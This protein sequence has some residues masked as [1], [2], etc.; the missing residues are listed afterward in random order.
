MTADELKALENA[1][2]QEKEAMENITSINLTLTQSLTKVQETILVISKQLKALQ[3]QKN[4]KKP[5]T[6]KPE[7]DNNQYLNKSKRYWWTHG[8]THSL[9]HTSAACR[10]LNK[11]HQIG[12]TLDSRMGGSDR[13]CKEYQTHE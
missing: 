6:E 4:T 9:N 5:A 1:T 7:T 12:A 10:Y 11:G 2:T 8:R 13:W 3:A